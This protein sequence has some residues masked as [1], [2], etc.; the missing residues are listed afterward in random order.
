MDRFIPAAA[1]GESASSGAKDDA[2][3]MHRM[4]NAARASEGLPAL[5]R[6]V[7]LDKLALAHVE[8]MLKANIVG[9]TLSGG[10]LRLRIEAAGLRTKIAGE[11]LASAKTLEN[12]HRALWTSPSHRDNLL[13]TQFNRIGVAAMRS[14]DGSVWV[15]EVFAD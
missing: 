15:T 2:D 5:E 8:E 10:D 4:V 6:D 9:H 12:A 3:A 13:R 11:N 7:S 1:P 14:S